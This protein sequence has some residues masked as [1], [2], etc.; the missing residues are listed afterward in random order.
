MKKSLLG[1]AKE[2]RWTLNVGE[3]MGLSRGLDY[4]GE[5]GYELVGIQLTNL[6]SRGEG[7]GGY[8]QPNSMYI[9]KRPRGT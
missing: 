6:E 9:F 4:M 2:G 3:V 5:Q 8:Y 7:S 1:A